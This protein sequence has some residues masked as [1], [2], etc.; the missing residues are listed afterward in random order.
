MFNIGPMEK[1]TKYV[2]FCMVTLEVPF[3][4]L[5]L[6]PQNLCKA[7]KRWRWILAHW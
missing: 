3:N 2:A 1:K 6:A 7:G 5:I 4:I